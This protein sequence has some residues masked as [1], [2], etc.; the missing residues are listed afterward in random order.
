M[1][2]FPLKTKTKE[3]ANT[4]A[5]TIQVANYVFLNKACTRVVR[6]LFFSFFDTYALD[7][8]RQVVRTDLKPLFFA[9][10]INYAQSLRA[11]SASFPSKLLL[12]SLKKKVTEHS[13]Q[14][15]SLLCT[16]TV[17]ISC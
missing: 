5:C 10:T 14:F 17:F 13:T 9:S 4:V 6:F 8:L 12:T 7:F 1:A 3:D 16:H 2:F 11:F 15:L